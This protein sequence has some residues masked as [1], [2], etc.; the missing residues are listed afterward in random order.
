M[1]LK[2]SRLYCLLLVLF[3]LI[4]CTSSYSKHEFQELRMGTLVSVTIYEKKSTSFKKIKKSVDEV[5]LLIE[6][7]Q[8]EIFDVNNPNSE[9]SIINKKLASKNKNTEIKDISKVYNNTVDSYT[10]FKVSDPLYEVFEISVDV[11]KKT[12]FAFDI[13]FK[14]VETLWFKSLKNSKIPN[15]K[16]LYEV[17]KYTGSELIKLKGSNR[18]LI[19]SGANI[20]LGGIAKGY[21]MD[22]AF[23]AL[24]SA[25]LN[26]FIINA[27][28]DLKLSGSKAGHAW[29]S[30][31][32]AAPETKDTKL[33]DLSKNNN[34]N[35]YAYCRTKDKDLGIAT[36]ASY[37]RFTEHDGKRYS[38][39]VDTRTLS[40]SESDILSVT[41]LYDEMSFADAYATAFYIKTYK[42]LIKDFDNL[43][44]ENIGV[45][46]INNKKE[47]KMNKTAARYCRF[48]Q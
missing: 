12:N 23:D 14:S 5:F 35:Y 1:F 32:L 39:I 6:K 38:H 40:P 19:K 29:V 20:A 47:K 25:G 33:L 4:G 44:Q 13:G 22:K 15:K 48:V 16:E 11:A 7:Y 30:S 26:N 28:G 18:V 9:I 37:Y 27:G 3:L 45:I 43:D 10:E 34:K 24:R 41:V 21:I 36:S 8:K 42:E 2:F 31:V 46:V 17:K